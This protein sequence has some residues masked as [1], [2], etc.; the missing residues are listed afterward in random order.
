MIKKIQ[1]ELKGL[2]N[3]EYAARLQKY[4]K[5]AKGEY[6]EGD[7]FLGIQVPVLRKTA[8]KY[9]T[10]AIGEVSGL[11][12]SQFHEERLF[13][14]LLLVDLFKRA[15]DKDQKQIYTRGNSRYTDEKGT[16]QILSKILA[17]PIH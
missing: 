10:L 11:I 4:F 2:A 12:K 16:S 8:K 3:P 7:R 9:R 1:K 13:S 14:L 17:S 15:D 6:G 5:T